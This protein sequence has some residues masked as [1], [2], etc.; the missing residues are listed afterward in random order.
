MVVVSTPTKRA[1][2]TTTPIQQLVLQASNWKMPMVMGLD[3]SSNS[4]DIFYIR[5]TLKTKYSLY[6]VDDLNR[7]SRFS[8]FF[9]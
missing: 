8:L 2:A 4:L 5:N 9:K 7:F 1:N 3:A 6:E